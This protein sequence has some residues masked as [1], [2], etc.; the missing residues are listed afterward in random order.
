MTT[1]HTLV[2]V[3]PHFGQVESCIFDP[4][5]IGLKL[6][7]ETVTS[8]Y[9]PVIQSGGKYDIRISG[10]S[11]SENLS[12]NVILCSVGAKYKEYCGNISRTFMVDAPK[13]VENTYGT[14]LDLY[15]VCIEQ[16]IVG[17]EFKDVLAAATDFL[18]SK[19]PE[20]LAHLPK[21]LGFAIGV[22]FRDSS[23][24]LNDK[25]N[26]NFVEGM[27]MNLVVGFHNVP[28]SA[29]DKKNATQ[30]YDQ[31]DQFSLLIADTV[32][33]QKDSIPEILTKLSKEFGDVSYNIG[34]NDKVK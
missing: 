22:Q 5:K 11:N 18:T 34:D 19:A 23:M 33:I 27:V 2:Q 20:L 17:K 4:S 30:A 25:N 24:L 31:M 13:K 21:S 14:L 9:T 7:S 8:C 32:Q 28:L 16:M 15:N 26:T 3:Y 6:S 10:T 12:A 29:D 1:V